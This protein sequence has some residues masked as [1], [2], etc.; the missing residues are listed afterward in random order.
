MGWGGGHP[1]MSQ[2]KR[3]C[4]TSM[5]CTPSF[6][7]FFSFSCRTTQRTGS[8]HRT[9]KR[10]GRVCGQRPKAH[11]G[12]RHLDRAALCASHLHAAETGRRPAVWRAPG[13]GRAAVSLCP[14][15]AGA[16]S[17]PCQHWHTAPGHSLPWQGKQPHP[18]LPVP[19]QEEVEDGLELKDGRG[20]PPAEGENE[21]CHLLTSLFIGSSQS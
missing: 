18:Q 6:S 13:K 8:V 21:R 20:K 3:W 1:S 11:R 16:G 9:Q 5:S 17:S 2:L 10:G 15:W 7:G 4:F 14:S 19:A 12:L